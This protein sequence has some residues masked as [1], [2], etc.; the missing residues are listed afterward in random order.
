MHDICLW[1]VRVN[2]GI[3][4]LS[5][6]HPTPRTQPIISALSAGGAAGGR[7]GDAIT[8]VGGEL[9]GPTE[10]PVACCCPGPHVEH[11]GGQGVEPFDV[12]VPGGRFHDAIAALV[13]VLPRQSAAWWSGTVNLEPRCLAK[14]VW[15]KMSNSNGILKIHPE[16]SCCWPCSI[17]LAPCA[18]PGSEQAKKGGWGSTNDAHISLII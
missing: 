5:H 14:T 2:D 13:L 12:G 10:V 16:G 8:C 3:P 1:I 9:E 15:S 11:V 7:G 6:K 17:P 18:A 4:H